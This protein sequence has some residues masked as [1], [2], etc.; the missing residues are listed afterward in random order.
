M[1][2]I[3]GLE[4]CRN[5]LHFW[6]E[7]DVKHTYLAQ[8]TKAGVFHFKLLKRQKPAL[9]LLSSKG[10]LC[11]NFRTGFQLGKPSSVASNRIPHRLLVC[12]T[13]ELP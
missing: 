2:L 8:V 10:H 9:N 5:D 11:A 13:E 7:C 1:G 3:T 6:P 4:L 12:G